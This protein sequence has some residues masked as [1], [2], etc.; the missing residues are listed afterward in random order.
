MK[1]LLKRANNKDHS[2]VALIGTPAL[3]FVIL[4]VSRIA[5][6][7]I[8]RA[9]PPMEIFYVRLGQQLFETQDKIDIKVSPFYASL[10]HWLNIF[11]NWHLTS[12]LL[13]TSFSIM[14]G[15]IVYQLA[16]EMFDQ[17]TAQFALAL[18]ILHP[19]LT[20]AVVGFS[21][22][23]VVS[24]TFLYLSVYAYWKILQQQHEAAMAAIGSVSATLATLVRPE[25]MLYFA[26]FCCTMLIK[27]IYSVAKHRHFKPLAITLSMVIVYS[28]LIALQYGFIRQ[29]TNSAYMNLFTDARYSYET[30][31]HTL[32]LRAVGSIDEDVA[33]KLALEAFGD[34]EANQYSIA[35]AMR[36]N[37][38]EAAKNIIFNLKEL[39]DIAGHPL[40]MPFFLYLLIGVGL[41]HQD[42]RQK[43]R[44]HLFLGAIFIPCLVAVT[45]MH[46][47]VRYLNPVIPPLIIWMALGMVHLQ[48]I[49]KRSVQ[50]VFFV[51]FSALFVVNSIF[52]SLDPIMK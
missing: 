28:S 10:I 25:L 39:L 22:T 51:L 16:R 37:P 24:T 17:P 23:V 20:F 11:N 45:I 21:H 36:N 18:L 2:G 50:Y 27:S 32:S 34:P 7:L 47:E 48:R 46:V 29:R 35:T 44:Q 33:R 6:P 30:Y 19:S 42:T 49:N 40:F 5:L 1:T 41:T 12:W 38:K 43:W 3:L 9:I 14:L 31:T 13:Y 15:L 26:L 52:Y 8:I 4:I